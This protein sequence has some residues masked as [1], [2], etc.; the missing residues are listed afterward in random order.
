MNR[1]SSSRKAIDAMTGF[2]PADLVFM[3]QCG[4]QPAACD[5]PQRPARREAPAQEFY[6]TDAKRIHALEAFAA[7]SFKVALQ[8]Q[9]KNAKAERLL[10]LVPAT[11]FAATVTAG[12]AIGIILWMVQR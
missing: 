6:A 4:I 2:K 7:Q 5:P 8:Q 3:A 11:I 9:T 10:S 1:P 12:G